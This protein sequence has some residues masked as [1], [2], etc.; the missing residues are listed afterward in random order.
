MKRNHLKEMEQRYAALSTEDL[1]KATTF[2]QTGYEPEAIALMNDELKRRGESQEDINMAQE[3]V[4]KQIAEISKKLT[5]IRGF[6][7]LFII[8]LYVNVLFSFGEV[9]IGL[10]L[11]GNLSTVMLDNT[12]T[13]LAVLVLSVCYVCVGLYGIFTLILL[14][15]KKKSAPG[16]TIKWIY[17]NLG[18]GILDAVLVF[19]NSSELQYFKVVGPLIFCLVWVTYFSRSKRVAATYG[20]NNGGRELR[21]QILDDME[22][23][24]RLFLTVCTE[25]ST[26][27]KLLNMM[28]DRESGLKAKSLFHEIRAKT[29]ETERSKDRELEAQYLFEE[30]CAKTLSNLSYPSGRFDPDSPYWIVPCAI[31]LARI[32]GI[33]DDKI[34]EIIA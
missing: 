25:T 21:M 6:L 22:R 30:I 15:R 1:I 34:I 3:T 23:L 4:A 31:D 20:I 24:I 16:H 12:S 29:L 13:I 5:G 11:F 14:I 17:S 10:I 32:K 2:E 8:M 26:M 33:P 18:I 27:E 28:K 19:L 9:L 7:L